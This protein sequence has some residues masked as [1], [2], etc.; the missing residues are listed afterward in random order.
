MSICVL[1]CKT[2]PDDGGDWSAVYKL[3]FPASYFK[4][5]QRHQGDF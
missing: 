4:T 5:T 3:K 1:Q 2:N